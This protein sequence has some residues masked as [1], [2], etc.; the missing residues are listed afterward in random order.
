MPDK[1]LHLFAVYLG[2]R[3]PKCNIELHDVVFVVGPSIEDTYSQLLDKW[4]G[5][6]LRMHIDSWLDL[7]VVD[8]WRVALRPE[9]SPGPHKL[10]FINLGAYVPGQFTELHANAFVV[11]T[12]GQE[13]NQRAKRDLLRGTDSL[14]TDDLYEIDD[15]L[16][17]GEVDGLHVHLEPTQERPTFEPRNGYH[18]IPKDVVEAYATRRGIAPISGTSEA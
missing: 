3:A 7:R 5:S 17:I 11:A 2:G 9:P 6:P 15:C 13:V 8:G 16:E 14:H 18:K 4:F 10:Y 1:T 12:S